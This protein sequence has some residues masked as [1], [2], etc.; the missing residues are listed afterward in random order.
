M[1]INAYYTARKLRR[2][3]HNGKRATGHAHATIAAQH[4]TH[5]GTRP[6]MARRRSSCAQ[7]R[8]RRRDNVK[9]HTS[10]YPKI[11]HIPPIGQRPIQIQDALR[12]F[13]IEITTD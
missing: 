3:N 12:V 8:R 9:L 1:P 6:A 13:G 11:I 7:I 4:V 10:N 5:D 2:A